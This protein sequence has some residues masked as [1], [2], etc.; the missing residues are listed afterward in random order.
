MS[1]VTVSCRRSLYPV[2]PDLLETAVELQAPSADDMIERELATVQAECGR[3]AAAIAQGGALGPLVDALQARDVRRRELECTL[4]AQRRRQ[5]S[6]V[7]RRD[8]ERRMQVALGKWA[9][10]RT[11]GR[12]RVTRGLRTVY[13]NEAAESGLERRAD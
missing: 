3:L 13:K 5:L 7:D 6:P 9:Q 8:L 2:R 4:A 11:W 12:H 1:F 10:V